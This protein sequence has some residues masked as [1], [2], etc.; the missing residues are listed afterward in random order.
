MTPIRPIEIIGGG[1]AGLSLGLALRRREVPV[2]VFE[3]GDYPRH[4]VCGEFIAGLSPRTV[5]K[6]G[7]GPFLQDAPRHRDVAWF[8]RDGLVRVERLPSPAIGLSRY[9]LDARL[10]RAFVEVGGD[11]RTHMRA[12][13]VSPKDG[14]V[15]AT[16]RRPGR[17]PWLGL[18][19]H[20]RK[21]QSLRGLEM[22]LGDHAYVGTSAV[23]GGEVNICGLFRRLPIRAHGADLLI[24]YLNASGLAALAS[25]VAAAEPDPASFCAIAAFSFDHRVPRRGQPSVGDACAVIPPF[26]GNGMA[27]AFQSAEAAVEPLAAYAHGETAWTEA[28]RVIRSSLGRQFRLRLASAGLIHPYLFNPRRQF[29]LVALSR[30]RL[31]PLRPIYAMLHS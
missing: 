9:E 20:V 29:W 12:T 2:T 30:A 27:M 11:L 7:L 19:I 5:E 15:F 3:A 22:H 31:L 24:A 1:L 18:K 16:G 17:S 25:R 14:R 4:R 21:W 8:H 13:D 10:A 6:L 26:T 23:E 28:C